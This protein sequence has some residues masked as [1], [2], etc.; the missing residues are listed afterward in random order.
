MPTDPVLQLCKR[1]GYRFSNPELVETALMH[2]SLGGA[3][4]ERMEFLGDSV[5]ALAVAEWL[6]EHK[7]ELEEGELTRMR[8]SLVN[9]DSLAAMAVELDLGDLLKTGKGERRRAGSV[10]RA[11]LEDTFEAVIGAVFLDGGYGRACEVVQGLFASRFKAMPDAESLKD[12]KTR[13]QE[14]LQ[15]RGHALPDY[16]LIG[17]LGPHHERQFETEC[18]VARLD[19]SCKGRGSSKRASEQRAAAAI[20]ARLGR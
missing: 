2:R 15:S 14:W 7:P 4:N 19:L 12:P 6:F 1:L 5:I 17:A 10:S 8:A 18:R 20:L 13:L 9:Q 3:S 16:R 11:M